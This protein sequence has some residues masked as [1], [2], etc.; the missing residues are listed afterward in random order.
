[1]DT[2]DLAYMVLT[3]KAQGFDFKDC[4]C[5]CLKSD[6]DVKA[7]GPE[8][9]LLGDIISK[10]WKRKADV[11]L[12][13][14]R[15]CFEI[16]PKV[17]VDT[18]RVNRIF[19]EYKNIGLLTW[20]TGEKKARKILETT[21]GRAAE[22]FLKQA[23]NARK[24]EAK[25]SD[26]DEAVDYQ[27][28][29]AIAM[30]DQIA[31]FMEK[32]PDA[33]LHPEIERLSNYIKVSQETAS[34]DKYEISK[35][36][37]L[38]QQKGPAYFE[39]MT[40]VEVGKAWTA[41]G[42]EMAYRNGVQEYMIVAQVDDP[43]KPC[44]VCRALHGKRF[45]VEKARENVDHLMSLTG[46]E[47]FAKEAPFP[48]IDDLKN[49][50]RE[51]FYDRGDLPS[52][53]NGCRCDVIMSWGG[54]LPDAYAPPKKGAKL[55]KFVAAKNK[56]DAVKYAKEQLGIKNVDLGNLDIRAIND[57]NKATTDVYNK[58]PEIRGQLNFIG[59]AQSRSTGIVDEKINEYIDNLKKA[60]IP[61]K[62]IKKATEKYTTTLLKRY[63]GKDTASSG[64]AYAS[65]SN[66]L[67]GNFRGVGFNEE[68]CGKGVFTSSYNE[69]CIGKEKIEAF[70]ESKR[71][72]TYFKWGVSRNVK[73]TMY[74]ELGHHVDDILKAKV[75]EVRKEIVDYIGS[76]RKKD[77]SKTFDTVKEGLSE[78]ATSNDAEFIAE[79]FCEYMSRDKPRDIAKHVGG[80]IDSA[81]HKLG[82]M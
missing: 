53:H 49:L 29:I 60:S 59:S 55:I 5:V 61:D 19:K 82:G 56:V 34:I 58:Y 36:L 38:I 57:M 37:D 54:T 23:K 30:G 77:V 64:M 68:W 35:R 75:P 40:D 72:D 50:S 51:E 11:F 22:Y 70:L 6:K 65:Y 74:H 33:I 20:K 78:Y 31:A 63:K 43:N 66:R 4:S 41:T 7:W 69:P 27:T 18:A 81:L 32:Y 62:D 17:K 79:S 52:F 2:F 80:I 73:E 14:L 76:F 46:T 12:T 15:E 8:A 13:S 9:R 44:P 21:T 48:R 16:D 10:I 42:I 24:K 25:K 67:W 71:I 1:M 47:D 45:S 28:F 39:Q 26:L 3:D